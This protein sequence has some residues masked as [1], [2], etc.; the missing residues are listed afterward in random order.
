MTPEVRS[1]LEELAQLEALE[2]SGRKLTPSQRTRLEAF[3]QFADYR[4]SL[5]QGD[6]HRGTLEAGGVEVEP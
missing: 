3:R 1:I 6:A 2:R 4:E 5:G